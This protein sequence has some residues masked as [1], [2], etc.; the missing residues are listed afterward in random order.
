MILQPSTVSKVVKGWDLLFAGKRNKEELAFVSAKF[1]K[2]FRGVYSDENF[3]LAADTVERETDFFPTI[4]SMLDVREVVY[5]RSAASNNNK[6]LPDP[7][8]LEK[9]ELQK[10]YEDL[11]LAVLDDIKNGKFDFSEATYRFTIIDQSEK[12]CKPIEEV[13]KLF[14]GND[15]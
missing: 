9:T 1:F 4:K 7:D 5:Q 2:A 6:A 13:K 11:R 10:S 14:K 12:I 3:K 8:A 15:R